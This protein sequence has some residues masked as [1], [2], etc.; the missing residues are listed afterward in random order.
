MKVKNG[1]GPPNVEHNLMSAWTLADPL[2]SS[3]LLEVVWK[4]LNVKGSLLLQE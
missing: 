3:E 1:S 2:W 4:F